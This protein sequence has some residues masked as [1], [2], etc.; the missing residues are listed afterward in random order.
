MG[1]LNLTTG[2]FDDTISE[3]TPATLTDMKVNAGGGNN[4]LDITD[5]NNTTAV[6][7]G[8]GADNVSIHSSTTKSAAAPVNVADN[9]NAVASQSSTLGP[10]VASNAIDG[11]P[12][13]F[14]LTNNDV[15]AYWQDSL[16]STYFLSSIDI[17]FSQNFPPL[18]NSNF[19]VSVL[20][21]GKETFGEDFYSG[22]GG[23][24]GQPGGV[25]AGCQPPQRRLRRYDQDPVSRESAIS[26]LDTSPSP[27]CRPSVFRAF[28]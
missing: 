25:P 27:T 23:I 9:P 26:D 17:V 22:T 18:Q 7:T 6:T 19:R 3:I 8:S 28:R 4:T 20:S 16:G 12:S 2:V 15:N 24:G 14:S 1:G 21:D 13:T 5:W 10:F 11:D